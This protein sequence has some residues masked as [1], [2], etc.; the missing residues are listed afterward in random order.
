MKVFRADKSYLTIVD[1]YDTKGVSRL[2][3]F[4]ELADV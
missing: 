1:E 4:A 3:D 2:E